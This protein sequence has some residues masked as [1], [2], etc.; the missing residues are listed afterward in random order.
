MTENVFDNIFTVSFP[1]LKKDIFRYK[2][3]IQIKETQK[4]INNTNPNRPTPRH[5]IIT[6]A[7]FKC[8]KRIR[9]VVREKQSYIQVNSLKKHLFLSRNLACKEGVTSYNQSSKT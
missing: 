9:K 4:G 2:K 5:I 6:T 8:K 3:D 1:K 7:N